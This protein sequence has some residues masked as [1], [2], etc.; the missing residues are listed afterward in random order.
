MAGGRLATRPTD[1]VADGDVP[2][3]KYDLSMQLLD[4]SEVDSEDGE[5]PFRLCMRLQARRLL[6]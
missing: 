1:L 6:R 3:L 2:D 5:L 4:R